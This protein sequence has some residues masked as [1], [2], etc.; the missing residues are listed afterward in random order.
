MLVKFVLTFTTNGQTMYNYILQWH[1]SGQVGICVV[2]YQKC[3]EMSG[4]FS[5]HIGLVIMCVLF[6]SVNLQDSIIMDQKDRD[7]LRSLSLLQYGTPL[8]VNSHGICS[9]LQ[10]RKRLISSSSLVQRFRTEHRLQGHHGCVNCINFS[11]E[12]DQLVSGSDDLKIMIWDWRKGTNIM[13]FQSQ[14]VANIF[15]VCTKM[16]S[17]MR[18]TNNASGYMCAC[19]IIV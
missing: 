15:Q 18:C 3:S 11:F 16:C 4:V 10:L 2:Q 19:N 17:S 13:N 14:H 9:S 12:G 7:F 8:I 5:M 6:C 1:N